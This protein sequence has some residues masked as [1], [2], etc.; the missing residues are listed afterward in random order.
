M[1]ITV[2]RNFFLEDIHLLPIYTNGEWLEKAEFFYLSKG[3]SKCSRTQSYNQHFIVQ[4]VLF[5]LKGALSVFQSY[6]NQQIS[7]ILYFQTQFVSLFHGLI[8]LFPEDKIAHNI[9]TGPFLT[10]H[11]CI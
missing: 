7:K 9:L 2:L 6:F 4:L 1:F 8:Y 11:I 5:H 10:T 3:I